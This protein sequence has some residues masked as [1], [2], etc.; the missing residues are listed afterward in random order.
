MV[1]INGLPFISPAVYSIKVDYHI[2]GS[3][4]FE[5]TI[6]IGVTRIDIT[7]IGGGGAGGASKS[8][9]EVGGGGGSGYIQHY[10]LRRKEKEFS[11]GDTFINHFIGSGGASIAPGNWNAT[12]NGGTTKISLKHT[13]GSI[14]TYSVDGGA[15]GN[16]RYTVVQNEGIY[17]GIGGNGGFGGGGSGARWFNT[18][19][20]CFG[21]YG[22]CGGTMENKT[23]TSGTNY[24]IYNFPNA[25]TG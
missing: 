17:I 1:K 4:A 10:T 13:D 8:T 7:L 15:G 9:Y 19:G 11:A 24:F 20:T 16:R 3:S 25:M 23:L 21:G 14:T 22:G 12:Q 6:P 2:T 18:I 5:L